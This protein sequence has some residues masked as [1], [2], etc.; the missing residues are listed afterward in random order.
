[1]NALDHPLP[2]ELPIQV[3]AGVLHLLRETKVGSRAAA[4][5]EEFEEEDLGQRGLFCRQCGNRITSEASRITV[6]GSHTHAFFNPAGILFELG[7]FREAPGCSVHGEASPHFTWFAGYVWRL[8]LCGRCAV[9][10]GWQFED[11]DATFF[12]LILSHLTDDF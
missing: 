9:H 10:L 1:M 3:G 12:C 8:A 7:C 6:N 11:Q 2:V 4:E 5:A